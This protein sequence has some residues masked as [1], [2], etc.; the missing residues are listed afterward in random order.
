ML[1]VMPLPLSRTDNA[2]YCI[3]AI[4]S[5]CDLQLRAEQVHIE[6]VRKRFQSYP[7][8]HAWVFIYY[9]LNLEPN[10]TLPERR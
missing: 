7:S 3:C 4:Y 6:R 5:R 8:L 10:S 2:M 1:I 9:F